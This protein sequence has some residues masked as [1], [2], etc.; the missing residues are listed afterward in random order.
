MKSRFYRP[1]SLACIFPSYFP[2]VA[3]YVK[4][5]GNYILYK[6]HDR[7]FTEADQNRLQRTNTEFLYVRSG[8]MEIVTEYLEQN[9]ESL[10]ARDDIDSGAKGTILYQTA[11][12]YVTDVF[13]EPGKTADII[14][15]RS[16]IRHLMKY[17]AGHEDALKALK[18]ITSQNYYIFTHSVQMAALMML[19]HERLFDLRQD[20]MIDVGVGSLLHDVGMVFL[21]GDIMNKPDA[22]ADIEYHK[23]KQHAQKGYDYLL[24]AGT[25]GEVSLTIVRH[26]HEKYDGSGYPVGLKGDN[27]PRS[28]Q[29]AALCDTYCAITTDRPKHTA[30]P[31][32]EALRL[33]GEEVGSVF[34]PELFKRFA[35][36]VSR[37]WETV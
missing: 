23:V 21:S 15:C 34:S 14:R 4:N 20:E 19:T 35:D 26:H 5:S 9:L 31:G 17:V 22:L 32:T 1:L 30:L 27:I 7:K 33:M 24:N 10:L 3:L 6:N 25:L 12:N 11:A 8:D 36:V 28:A 16:L 29:L 18:A 37:K 13:D 2:D